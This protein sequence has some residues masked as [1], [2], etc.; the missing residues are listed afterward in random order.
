MVFCRPYGK[1]NGNDWREA[2]KFQEKI[3]HQKVQLTLI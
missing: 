2:V 3:K 1:K